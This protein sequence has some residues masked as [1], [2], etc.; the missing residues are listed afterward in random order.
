MNAVEWVRQNCRFAA[1]ST[2]VAILRDYLKQGLD[3]ND[4][5]QMLEDYL[6]QTHSLPPDFP[7]DAP[8]EYLEQMNETQL[9]GFK[10]WLEGKDLT[11]EGD[12]Y[13]PSYSHLEYQKTV[14][15]GTWLIHFSDESVNI[16]NKGFEYGH[17]DMRSL[18]LTTQF[19]NRQEQAGWNFAFE[20]LSKHAQKA[21]HDSHYGSEAILFRSAGVAAYHY[22]DEENQVI[23]KGQDARDLVYLERTAGQDEFSILSNKNDRVIFKGDYLAVVKWVIANFN[24]YRNVLMRR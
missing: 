13:A 5:A 19:K 21:A 22:G 14:P 17:E 8:Y 6:L 7:S 1:Y 20:A 4:Y 24:Q 12:A 2:D 15:P 18:G 3:P 10:K 11:M 16:R 23:F 9:V